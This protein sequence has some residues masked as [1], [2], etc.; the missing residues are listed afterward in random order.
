MNHFTIKDIENLT[1]IKAHTWRTWETRYGIGLQSRDASLHRHY[2]GEDLKY[3]LRIS[4][5]YHAGYKISK[6]AAFSEEERINFSLS[7]DNFKSV[8]D[9]YIN[10]LLLVAID[11]NDLA[12]K[13]LLHQAWHKIGT[14]KLVVE[15]IYPLQARLGLLWLTNHIV[16]SQ[17]HFTSNLIR[18]LLC[19]AIDGLNN[20]LH[21]AS[22]T[23]LLFAPEKE[24]HELPLLFYHYLLKNAGCRVIYAG[25]GITIEE[26]CQVTSTL[27]YTISK[28]MFNLITNLNSISAEAYLKNLCMRLPDF[29][30]VM[31][32]PCVSTINHAPINATL[33]TSLN[34]VINFC[35]NP[36]A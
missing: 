24:Y 16:P 8:E 15:V 32:G 19:V 23:I 35:K 27:P 12:F 36:V 9:Y 34:E 31:S 6:I 10:Q 11:L 26:V 22:P 25:C 29:N 18:E 1:S 3:I 28:V 33:L 14:E 7:V 17:E 2:S 20:K 30:I 21:I 13:D 5:L 4:N